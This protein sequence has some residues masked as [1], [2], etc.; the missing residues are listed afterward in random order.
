MTF[1]SVGF[2]SFVKLLISRAGHTLATEVKVTRLAAREEV[3]LIRVD[4]PVTY[5]AIEVTT[6]G[7]KRAAFHSSDLWIDEVSLL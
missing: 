2:E 5:V 7:L 6:V 1:L 4:L 3:L